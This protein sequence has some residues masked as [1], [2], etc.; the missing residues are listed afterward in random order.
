MPK[1]VI[2]VLGKKLD[3]RKRTTNCLVYN[4]WQVGCCD[5]TEV[6]T[7]TLDDF[8][9]DTY[10]AATAKRNELRK[11]FPKTEYHITIIVD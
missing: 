10:D 9:F 5:S 4:K 7:D 8:T 11:K 2:I 6:K 1:F 3:G